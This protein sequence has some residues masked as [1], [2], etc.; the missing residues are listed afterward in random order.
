MSK[1]SVD[2]KLKAGPPPGFLHLVVLDPVRGRCLVTME[3]TPEAR[4]FL[5]DLQR[6]TVDLK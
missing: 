3:D 1:A 6:G 2:A 4:A 5:A